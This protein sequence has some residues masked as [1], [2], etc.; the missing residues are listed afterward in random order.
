[1]TF[2][3]RAIAAAMGAAATLTAALAVTYLLVACQS[4][5]GLLGPVAGDTHPRTR[6]GAVLLVLAVLFAGG[7]LVLSRR[8]G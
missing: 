8:D 3:R 5:P 2:P 7:G 6:L 1:M 4:L